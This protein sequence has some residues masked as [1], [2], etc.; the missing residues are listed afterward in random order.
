ME[1]LLLHPRPTPGN[2][3]TVP[4]SCLAVAAPQ[5]AVGY[6]VRILDEFSTANYERTLVEALAKTDLV[7][8]SCFTGHQIKCATRSAELIRRHSPDTPIVWG[9]YHPSLYPAATVESELADYVITGQGEWTFLKLRQRLNRGETIDETPGLWRTQNGKGIQNPGAPDFRGIENFPEYPFDLID[10]K[11]FLINSLTPRSISYHSSLGCPFRC[12]FCTVTEIYN[13]R[14]SGFTPERVIRDMRFLLAET[15]AASIE[16]YDNNFFVNDERTFQIARSLL[17]EG[18]DILWSA[19][20]RPD[21]IAEFDDEMLSLLHRSGLRWVFIGAESGHDDVLEMM[22]RDHTAAHI[23]TAAEKLAEHRIK[24]TF[25]FNLGYPGEPPDNFEKTERLAKE[26][27][28]L[29][30][31]TELMIYIT[32][33]Y[34][35]TPAFHKAAELSAKEATSLTDWE[36]LDQRSGD[37]K[38]WLEKKYSRKL[39]NYTMVTFYAT[40]F[41]HRKLRELY[42]GNPFLHLLHLLADFHHRFSWYQ[43][44]LDLRITH[45]LFRMT[46]GKRD[47][48]REDMWSGRS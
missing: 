18:F 37:R 5:R 14:W 16:F 10:L 24:V 3:C 38:A 32:T 6:P 46:S 7:G 12:N 9:G 47:R 42:R 2:S 4:Y 40:S 22:D 19:E 21:K 1:T 13:R 31:Q 28:K 34:E 8:I 33:A 44:I 43:T 26:L 36:H 17:D 39:F 23:L 35:A 48:I 25:S 11:P 45:R 20:A 29:N 41:L 27:Q 15:N 30:G